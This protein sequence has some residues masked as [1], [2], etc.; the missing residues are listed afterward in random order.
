MGTAL[1]AGSATFLKL[2]LQPYGAIWMGAELGLK[3]A[4]QMRLDPMPFPALQAELGVAQQDY[5]GKLA[6]IL[7]Q[8]PGLQL[9]LCGEA[10]RDDFAALMLSVAAANGEQAP[11]TPAGSGE[12]SAPATPDTEQQRELT[13]LADARARGLKHWLVKEK[14][15]DASRLYLCKAR[16]DPEGKISGVKM[17]L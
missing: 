6:L 3:L 5:A 12:Q 9:Q 8:R 7:D 1:Q 11:Q 14:G 10:G 17:S 4:G 16:A 13:T 2:A 15:I